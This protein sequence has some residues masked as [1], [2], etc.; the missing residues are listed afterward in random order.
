MQGC[1]KVG[2]LAFDLDGVLV[3][4]RSSWRY[5]HLRFG[6]ITI[7]ESRDDARAFLEGRISYEEWM[8]RDLEAIIESAGRRLSREE[9]VN[10]FRDS[11][12]EEGAEEVVNYA[13]ALGIELAIVSGGIDI[14]A[15]MVARRLGI[16]YVMA[17]KLVFDN[18]DLLIPRG[19]EIV[20]P[21]RK[22]EALLKISRETGIPL[23][24]FI[25]VGDT[26]W[27]VSAFRVVG[28]PVLYRRGEDPVNLGIEVYTIDR[29]AELKGI[30]RTIC[31]MGT[32]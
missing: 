19:I 9:I 14:L 29:L 4:C 25:Y 13:K 28:Y 7:V 15:N 21:L 10:V 18:N 30:L 12:L 24:R 23:N 32:S 11:E 3:K 20:N 5:L 31:K 1:G 2:V 6:S 17:N 27:D 26:S 22:D 16:R 8:R